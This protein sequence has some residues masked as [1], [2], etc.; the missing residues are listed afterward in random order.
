MNNIF[1][2]DSKLMGF[3]NTFADLLWL[4]LLTVISSL[5][6]V[7]IGASFT[8]MHAVLLKIRKNDE[9]HITR[10][11]FK[12]FKENLRQSTIIWII[13]LIYYGALFCNFY[14]IANQ[15]FILP[16]P[17]IWVLF[18]LLIITSFSLVWVFVLQSRYRN[19]IFAT[20]KNSFIIAITNP[21]PTIIMLLLFISPFVLLY[22][23]GNLE[24]LVLFLG[25]AVP[26]FIQTSIYG[27]LFEKIESEEFT[28]S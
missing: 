7:T 5:P 13:Y 11:F 18:L 4:N 17:I 16:K 22:F 10:T 27:G 26:G 6:I 24:P 15:L 9:D 1:G 21:G 19:P 20:L 2:V 8:A 3:M 23:A 28:N 14:L 12:A 25:F